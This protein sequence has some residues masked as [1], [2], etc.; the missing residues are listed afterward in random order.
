[1][2]ATSCPLGLPHGVA[3]ARRGVPRLRP[4][5]A[6]LLIGRG[7]GDQRHEADHRFLHAGADVYE[8]HLFL[9]QRVQIGI[10]AIDAR[11]RAKHID[12]D[13]GGRIAECGGR[14][15]LFDRAYCERPISALILR[16]SSSSSG[17]SLVSVSWMATFFKSPVNLNGT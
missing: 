12:L 17:L 10:A 11:T 7:K 8:H 2:L 13:P 14:G 3:A 1:M 15:Q 16:I 9:K 5:Q 4:F 6:H